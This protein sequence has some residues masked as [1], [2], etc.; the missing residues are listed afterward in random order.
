[1]IPSPFVEYM[2]PF[3]DLI[4]VCPE[5]EIGLGV[6]RKPMRMVF[7]G[8]RR[9]VQPATGIELTQKMESFADSY[10]EGLDDFDGFILKSR[11]PSCGIGTTKLYPGAEGGEWINS[12]ENGF[13]ADAVIRKYPQLPAVNEEQLADVILRD[14][15]LTV[16]FTLSSFREASSSVSVHS[17]IEYHSR[18]KLLLMA[19]DKDLMTSMGNI[20]ANRGL[21]SAEDTFRQYLELLLQA[22]S[23]PAE[24]GP[25]INALMHAF[26]Y[27]SRYLGAQDKFMFLQKLQYYR[28]NALVQ[29][30]LKEKIMYWALQFNVEYI[31]EQT[32]LCPYP[33]ELACSKQNGNFR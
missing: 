2:K 24:T 32:F 16:I 30:E 28:G 23:K 26:G 19:Y 20:V 6:P 4:A 17:L 33:Q 7:D 29:F 8:N 13:F 31:S 3:A 1:M 9:L 14:H 18:N 11:S 10:L 15:F 27:L 12:Q 21:L 22:L 25:T 5:C